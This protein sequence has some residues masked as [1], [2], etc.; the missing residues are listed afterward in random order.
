MNDLVDT[1]EMYLR[2]IYDLEEEG[3][4]PLRARIAERLEQS[5]PTVS[6]TV[7]RMERDGL[8][9]V[10][11]DRHLELT[12]KGRALA[13][14]VMRK[15]RLAERLLVDVIGLPWEEVHAEA[16]RWEHVMSEDVERRLVKVLDNPTTSPFG[17]PIPGL[18]ELGVVSTEPEDMNLVRLTELPAGTPVPVVVRQLTE[19][20]QGDVELITR[21]KEAGVVPNARVTVQVNEN[22]SVSI[23]IPGHEQVDLPYQMAHAVKVEKV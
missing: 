12:E 15:H 3:V 13:I 8:L 23:I 16:C 14:S 11:G 7:S 17:N 6:Q 20:V 18:S 21:L 19:H 10:A 1:T 9:Q 22:K 4:V 5:G 2:T